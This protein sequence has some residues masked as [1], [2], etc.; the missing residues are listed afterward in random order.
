MMRRMNRI[1]I[2][3]YEVRIK[4]KELQI[5][6]KREKYIVARGIEVDICSK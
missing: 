6:K 3:L 4:V 1:L 2:F 5:E